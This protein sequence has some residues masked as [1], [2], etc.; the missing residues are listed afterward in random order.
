MDLEIII[1]SEVRERKTNIWYHLYV[2][3]K[4][5]KI[6]IHLFIKQNQTQKKKTNLL[7]KR[8]E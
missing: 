5:K 7:P 8:K 1:L 4:K 3:M 6:Q 2:G